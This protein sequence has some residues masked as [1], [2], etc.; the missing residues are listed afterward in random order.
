MGKISDVIENGIKKFVN[1]LN[2]HYFSLLK[3]LTTGVELGGK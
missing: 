3:D 2:T 1:I